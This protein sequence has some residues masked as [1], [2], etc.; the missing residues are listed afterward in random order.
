M[1]VSIFPSCPIQARAGTSMNW[2]QPKGGNLRRRN[3]LARTNCFW[4]TFGRLLKNTLPKVLATK[5]H[6]TMQMSRKATRGQRVTATMTARITT[7]Q[8]AGVLV[9]RGVT[10]ILKDMVTV[11]VRTMAGRKA[12]VMVMV[13]AMQRATLMAKARATITPRAARTVKAGIT[14]SRMVTITMGMGT[15]RRTEVT[16][17]EKAGISTKQRATLMVKAGAPM[18]QEVTT[19]APARMASAM[20]ANANA[21]FTVLATTSTTGRSKAATFLPLMTTGLIARVVDKGMVVARI[22]GVTCVIPA[23]AHRPRALRQAECG[24]W[25]ALSA[26]SVRSVT[27]QGFQVHGSAPDGLQ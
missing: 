4:T 23:A 6:G 14:M 16:I 2:S 8:R 27:P 17:M 26:L 19:M 3:W 11:K 12:G 9:M 21:Q 15:T 7:T 20:V 24:S 10:M 1:L 13:T 5:P 22:V 18:R 25:S